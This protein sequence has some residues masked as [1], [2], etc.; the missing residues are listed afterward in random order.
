MREKNSYAVVAAV[1]LNVIGILVLLIIWG[2]ASK[3]SDIL[4]APCL[5]IGG[6]VQL[7]G[8]CYFESQ[9]EGKKLTFNVIFF[10]VMHVVVAG[11]AIVLVLLELLSG[12]D[13]DLLLLVLY[14]LYAI[15]MGTIYDGLILPVRVLIGLVEYFVKHPEGKKRLLSGAGILV[16]TAIFLISIIQ[17]LGMDIKSSFDSSEG[18]EPT[19]EYKESL[20]FVER[21][22][23]REKREEEREKQKEQR[24]S[25]KEE[26]KPEKTY[27]EEECERVRKMVEENR[28]EQWTEEDVKDWAALKW[29]PADGDYYDGDYYVVSIDCLKD[30]RMHGKVDLSGFSH[31]KRFD[32]SWTDIEEVILP[33]S[34]KKL[35]N[36]FRECEN[37]KKITFGKGFERIGEDTFD[38][39]RKLE[40]LVFQGD[41]PKLSNYMPVFND[42]KIYYPKGA[43]GWNEGYW[44]EYDTK[45]QS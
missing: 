34:I 24:V 29:E 19:G 16:F 38:Y 8:Y 25:E 33:D 40:T 3:K 9:F 18:N 13:A 20:E 14:P 31:L 15:G 26:T 11:M 45:P 2:V 5:V 17:F 36:E 12:G 41:A 28:D 42:A 35:K 30:E 22:K 4:G 37:L 43:K 32:F 6:I 44:K 21:I 7:A 27:N 1:V 10:A 39:S 23:E